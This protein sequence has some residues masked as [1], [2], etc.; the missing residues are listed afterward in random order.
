MLYLIGLGLGNE[1][2]ITLNAL[3]TIKKCNKIYLENYTSKLNCRITDLEKLYNKKIILADRDLVEK[4]AETTILKDAEKKDTAFLVMGDIFGATTHIDLVLRAKKKDIKVKFIHNNS[5]MTAIGEAG[6]ELYKFGKT[7]SMVFFDDKWKPATAYDVIAMN[8]MNGLHTL[9]LL[10]IKTAEPS[11]E[12]LMKDKNKPMPPR[13]MTVNQCLNQLLELENIKKQDIITPKTKVIGCA[14]LGTDDSI[15]KYGTIKELLDFDFGDE[16]HCV[17]I[18][19]KLH[20]M[21]EEFL[22]SL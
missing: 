5:I 8:Q 19:G 4:K 18:P 20:F 9:I 2:D 16:M 11:K 21:E 7:S 22:K 15:I 13:Y 1:K 12:D 17:I 3:E 14:R 6:L 10:D